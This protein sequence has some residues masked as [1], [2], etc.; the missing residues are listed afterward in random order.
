MEK[1]LENYIIKTAYNYLTDYTDIKVYNKFGEY[2]GALSGHRYDFDEI[3]DDD[4]DCALSDDNYLYV[5]D[6]PFW[7]GVY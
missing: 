6:G 4:I 1:K 7:N 3:T 2:L 5:T